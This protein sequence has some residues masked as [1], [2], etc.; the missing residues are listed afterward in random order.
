MC[1]AS[2]D[3]DQGPSSGL[4]RGGAP[5]RFHGTRLS[6]SRREVIKNNGGF[7]CF[8]VSGSRFRRWNFD[9]THSMGDVT[10]KLDETT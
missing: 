10:S 5:I 9:V 1:G 2:D 4:F 6:L 8:R 7:V 3:V